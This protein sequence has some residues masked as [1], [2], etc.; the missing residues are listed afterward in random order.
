MVFGAATLSWPGSFHRL[1]RRSAQTQSASAGVQHTILD[2][3]LGR[4][5]TPGLAHS[6][7]DGEN[8]GARLATAVC[9]PAV[10]AHN[11][12]WAHNKQS[13]AE[14]R[15][16]QCENCLRGPRH[17]SMILLTSNQARF[18]QITPA[19]QDGA[20][21]RLLP[22][23]TCFPTFWVSPDRRLI[24]L[25]P[26]CRSIDPN[27]S[28][29]LTSNS[30]CMV[31]VLPDGTCGVWP[32]TGTILGSCVRRIPRLGSPTSGNPY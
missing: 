18:S 23:L 3:A 7:P 10:L 28:Q 13:E 15:R 17:S 29:L 8:R 19:D 24:R 21:H 5:A 20:T 26:L 14:R 32:P 22:L 25:T 31:L 30:S 6:G 12:H 9:A 27:V 2:F 16:Y 1:E 11:E 4:G